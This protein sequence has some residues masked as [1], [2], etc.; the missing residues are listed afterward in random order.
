[1]LRLYEAIVKKIS[2]EHN[3]Q[4]ISEAKIVDNDGI[5]VSIKHTYMCKCGKVKQ[6]KVNNQ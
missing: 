3:F 4:K 6:V 1:M 5:I 2:H